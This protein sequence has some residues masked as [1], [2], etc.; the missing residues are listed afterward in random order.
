MLPIV[1][2]I[3]DENDRAFV[4]KIYRLYGKKIYL[5]ALKILNNPE[6]AEDCLHDVIKTVIDRLELFRG[7]GDEQLIKLLVVCTRNTAIDLYRKNKKRLLMETEYPAFDDGEARDPAAV[8]NIPDESAFSDLILINEENRKRI[9]EMIEEL[10][11]IYRDI[12]YL[13]YRY[14]M[15][16][17]EIAKIL[18]ISESTVKVR[19]LRAKRILLQKRGKELD[20]M[21]KT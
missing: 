13:R 10:D 16:N 20:E 18:N 14:S 11:P 19:Y 3:A 5:S 17:A 15:K 21:R 8:E 9:A 12:L 2:T 7:A 1:L 4:E 6:D